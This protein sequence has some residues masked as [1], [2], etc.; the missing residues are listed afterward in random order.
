MNP[1]YLRAISDAARYVRSRLPSSNTIE[2]QDLVQVGCERVLRYVR[3]G[4]PPVVAFICAR[5]GMVEES[6]RWAQNAWAPSRG[7][8]IRGKY[9]KMRRIGDA[10]RLTG[11]HEWH[12]CIPAPDM[13]LLIDI[14]RTLL[15]LPLREAVAWHSQHQLDRPAH[16]L[17]PE[18]GVS[19][20]RIVQL[21]RA[22]N[23]K[24][25]T[26][27][28]PDGE[29]RPSN[30]IVLATARQR[31]NHETQ[32]RYRELRDLGASRKMALRGAKSPRLFADATRILQ[33]GPRPLAKCGGDVHRRSL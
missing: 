14:K 32:R 19:H 28:D 29:M 10:P 2:L 1:I 17:A 30:T 26:V 8:L 12:R 27:V 4:L 25:R 18:F 6:R 22:A 13:A 24:L 16:E 15:S 9:A 7:K 23:D 21:A 31:Y 5:D 3:E 11:F 33:A 20:M